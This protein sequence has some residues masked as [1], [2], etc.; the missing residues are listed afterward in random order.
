MGVLLLNASYEPLR[1]VSFRRA[2]ALVLQEKATPVST[3]ADDYIVSAGGNVVMERPDVIRLN[4]YVKIP[5]KAQVPLNNR[6]VLNRDR[7]TCGYCGNHATTI[8][9]VHPKSKGGKHEWSNVIAACRRCNGTKADK[10]LSDLGWELPY[11]PGPPEARTWI[12]LAQ[13]PRDSWDQWLE[14]AP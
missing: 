14:S 5:Y 13:K 3:C 10:L 8:D 7:F 12:V 2:V 9:H 11:I 4:Y 6:A 1:V